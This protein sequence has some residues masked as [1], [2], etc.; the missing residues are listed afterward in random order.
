MALDDKDIFAAIFEKFSDQSI[1]FVM[2][3]YEKAKRLNR[4]IERR[5][6][7]NLPPEAESVAL[8]AAEISAP[9]EEKALEA[10]RRKKYSRRDLVCKPE[11][12]IS[13]AS[14]KCCLCG[15]EGSSLTSRHLAQH[16]ISV[17]DYKKLCGYADD[18]K[19]MSRNFERK[20][21]HNVQ[22][23]QQVRMSN[24]KDKAAAES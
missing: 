8:D 22:R 1:E 10:P 19:L 13:D 11:E 20:M 21:L 16:D 2:A 17:E 7:E 4:E 15:K 18:Q 23:A 24:L 6:A 3:Q 12:A 5:L 14:I 9:D